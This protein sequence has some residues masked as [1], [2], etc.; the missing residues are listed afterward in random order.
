MQRV[1]AALVRTVRVV[2]KCTQV[3]KA[4]ALECTKLRVPTKVHKIECRSS[5]HKLPRRSNL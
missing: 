1:V 3:I 2:L 4:E 5:A